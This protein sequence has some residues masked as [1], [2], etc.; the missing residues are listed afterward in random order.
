MA[1]PV[2]GRHLEAGGCNVF[3][4]FVSPPSLRI[5]LI[6]RPP[7]QQPAVTAP[8]GPKHDEGFGRA[9]DFLRFATHA[10]ASSRLPSRGRHMNP[11]TSRYHS[12]HVSWNPW[13]GIS[14][15][16]MRRPRNEYD[17]QPREVHTI[18]SG[19]AEPRVWV[20]SERA[21]ESQ[22][23]QQ[24]ETT[25]GHYGLYSILPLTPPGSE[26]NSIDADGSHQT[27]PKELSASYCCGLFSRRPKLASTAAAPSSELPVRN[28]HTANAPD[29]PALAPPAIVPRDTLD[30]P[31][32]VDPPLPGS[33]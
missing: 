30:L 28:D 14:S 8:T 25:P 7:L 24:L 13:R 9:A 12:P 32:V 6:N 16:L 21:P 29:L 31:A 2:V 4:G 19:Y 10:P 11:G 5:L 23:P 20:G 17:S 3:P 26:S 27:S 1:S 33:S 18:R 22:L 15:L